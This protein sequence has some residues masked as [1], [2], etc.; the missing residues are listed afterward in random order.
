LWFSSELQLE[1]LCDA[2]QA[3]LVLQKFTFDHENVYEWGIADS[4]DSSWWINV[5]RK[6]HGGCPVPAEPYHCLVGG[7]PPE[8]IELAEKISIQL[9]AEVSFGRIDYLGG[10]DYAYRPI[11]SAKK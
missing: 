5:S 1:P 7:S 8:F 3:A 6:H 2:L 10:D 9:H 4:C 11:G